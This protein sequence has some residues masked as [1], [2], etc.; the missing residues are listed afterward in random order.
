MPKRGE[1]HQHHRVE[2]DDEDKEPPATAQAAPPVEKNVRDLHFKY[3][4]TQKSAPRRHS[5]RSHR[6]LTLPVPEETESLL[7]FGQEGGATYGKLSGEQ[8]A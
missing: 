5:I 1:H 7:P 4:T 2:D 8:A 6:R 3:V